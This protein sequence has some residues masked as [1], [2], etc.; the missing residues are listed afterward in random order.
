MQSSTLHVRAVA[1]IVLTRGVSSI[2]ELLNRVNSRLCV[3]TNAT[4]G[5]M[6]TIGIITNY[7]LDE[8]KMERHS[9]CCLWKV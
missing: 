8:S 3:K 5:K 2:F 7:G 4:R 9:G 6:L 1:L